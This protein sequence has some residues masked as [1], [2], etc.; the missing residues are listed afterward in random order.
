[1]PKLYYCSI[2]GKV[3]GPFAGS[4]ITQ[5]ASTGE[6][7]PEDL[8]RPEEQEDWYKAEAI[9]GLFDTDGQAVLAVHCPGC[10]APLLYDARF[11][12]QKFRCAKC[13]KVV[14]ING[15]GIPRLVG[16]DA[17][18]GQASQP[19]STDPL[20][21]KYTCGHCKAPLETDSSLGGKEEPCPVCKKV[22]PVPLSKAQQ[23]EQK[24]RERAMQRR[25]K[26]DLQ[27][28]EAERRAKADPQAP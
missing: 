12:G 22:N 7:G 10:K 19:A 1:M 17:A 23:R 3:I 28:E 21:I 25:I 24:E 11:F 13:L 9:E 14:E 20:P 18:G 5:M 6:L 27:R 4:V 26:E 8:V 2:R 15:K 16:P